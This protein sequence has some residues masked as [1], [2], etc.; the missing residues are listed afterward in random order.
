MVLTGT[1]L[2]NCLFLASPVLLSLLLHLLIHSSRKSVLAEIGL[3]LDHRILDQLLTHNGEVVQVLLELFT[4]N[5]EQQLLA[6]SIASHMLLNRRRVHIFISF[7]KI[8]YIELVVTI[9][10]GFLNA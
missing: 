10:P 1:L 9:T 2:S 5:L 8:Y 4:F 3:N 7:Y 6:D